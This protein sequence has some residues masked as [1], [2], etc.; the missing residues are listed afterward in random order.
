[1]VCSLVVFLTTLLSSGCAHKETYK[2]G[3]ATGEKTIAL[4][5][6]QEPWAQRLQQA[7]QAAGYKVVIAS[8]AG[9]ISKTL[10]DGS[11]LTQPIATTPYVLEIGGY[12]SPMRRCF[13]GG[14]YF[15][16]FSAVLYDTVGNQ[17]IFAYYDSG[18]SENCPPLSGKLYG[19]VVKL[20]NES[21]R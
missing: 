17:Q 2:N 7:I 16:E 12:V 4:R 1:M 10:P 3:T 20:L 6:P 14:Q 15:D 5:A 19:N 13:G 8:Q 9:T 11:I 18:Y 21:W